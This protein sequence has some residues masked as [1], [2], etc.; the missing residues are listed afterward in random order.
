MKK[1][2]AT[3]SHPKP[4]S[5][6][7]EPAGA[8]VE[9]IPAPPAE[10]A[11]DFGRMVAELINQNYALSQQVGQVFGAVKNLYDAVKAQLIQVDEVKRDLQQELR[12]LQTGG[13]QRA[14]AGVYCKLFRDL[15]RNINQMDSVI[16][17]AEGHELD[18][19]GKAWLALVRVNRDQ[20]ESILAE[21][22]V[23]PIPVKVGEELFD[24]EVHEAVSAM[25]GEVTDLAPAHVIARVR[26]RGWRLHEEILQFPQVLVG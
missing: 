25:P 18:E 20:F 10:Q 13:A 16:A 14:M 7:A 19:T 9:S 4:A 3:P 21:W 12:Q 6:P 11:W 23:K 1:T 15:I 17:N 5:R 26:R 24:P 8:G 22:G 2:H